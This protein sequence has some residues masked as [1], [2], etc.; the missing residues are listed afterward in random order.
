MEIKVFGQEQ[1]VS[2]LERGVDTGCS[3]LISIGNPPKFWK[4][5]P[6]STMPKIFKKK[7]KKILR[8]GFHDISNPDVDLKLLNVGRI[9]QMEDCKKIVAFYSENKYQIE[10]LAIHCWAGVSRS[11][12]AAMALLY[13]ELGSEKAAME[14]LAKIRKQA[15]PN[16]LMLQFFDEIFGSELIYYRTLIMKQVFRDNKAEFEALFGKDVEEIDEETE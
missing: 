4:K 13:L 9:P 11:T 8:L 5:T 7:F 6:D 15:L 14:K 16:G 10:G 12:A 2:L 1:L 3:H